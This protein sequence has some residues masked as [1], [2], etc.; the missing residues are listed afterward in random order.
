M[1][2]VTATPISRVSCWRRKF[3]TP[4]E[5]QL[6][7]QHETFSPRTFLFNVDTKFWGRE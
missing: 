3:S 4:F 7:R 2:A 5:V 1:T 6:H